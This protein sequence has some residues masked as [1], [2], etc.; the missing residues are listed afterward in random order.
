[1][2]YKDKEA[3]KKAQRK[4]EKEKREV[5]GEIWGIIIYPD[6]MPDNWQEILEDLKVPVFVSPLHDRDVNPTGEPKKPHYHVVI[7]FDGMKSLTQVKEISNKLNAPNP[8]KQDSWRGSVRYLCHLDTPSK[9]RYNDDDVI[10]LGGADYLSVITN[11]SEKYEIIGEIVDWIVTPG[12]EVIHHYSFSDTF[13]FAKAN[14]DRWYRAMCDNCGWIIIEFLKSEFWTRGQEKNYREQG[15]L[16]DRLRSEN[17]R[18]LGWI[19]G[20]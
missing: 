7:H 8:E 6:S 9:A 2:A 13:M 18:L 1:M 12:N 14:N 20:D 3:Q 15:Q 17:D 19:E 11:S 5:R 4:Y 16:A 10:S